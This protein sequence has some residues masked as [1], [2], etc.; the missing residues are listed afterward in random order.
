MA[1]LSEVMVKK[2]KQSMNIIKQSQT[3]LAQLNP[4]MI[5]LVT[6][7]SLLGTNIT[8]AQSANQSSESISK[9]TIL[10]D[11]AEVTRKQTVKCSGAK[12]GVTASFKAL[13]SQIQVK[14]LRASVKGP[15]KVIGVTHKAQSN[16]PTIKKQLSS[17]KEQSKSQ[18]EW[19]KK[20]KAILKKQQVLV[21]EKVRIKQSEGLV[22][23]EKERVKQAVAQGL[24]VGQLDFKSLQQ[25]L[26]RLH[27]QSSEMQKRLI[28]IDE[29]LHELRLE[30]YNLSQ[31]KP[32]A[33]QAVSQSTQAAV[34]VHGGDAIVSMNCSGT[35]ILTVELSYVTAGASWQ[36][37][38][39]V[40]I[41]SKSKNTA[42]VS[43][44]VNAIVRQSTGEDWQEAQ[45]YLS[46]AQPNLGDRSPLPRA[47]HIT[48]SEHS[49]Q[50]VLSQR[51]E[52]RQDLAGGQAQAPSE[53]SSVGIEDRGQS[54]GLKVPQKLTILSNGQAYWIPVSVNKT[55]KAKLALVSTP[56]LS[57]A[58]YKVVRFNNP[59]P[60]PMP[61]GSLALN[62]DGQYLGQ[63]TTK[64]YGQGEPVEF[65]LGAEESLRVQ[66][67]LKKEKDKKAGLLESDQTLLRHFEIKLSNSSKK[68]QKVEVV[69]N[70]PVS[71]IEDIKVTLNKNKARGAINLIQKQALFRG[72]SV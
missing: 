69:D 48:G 52:D 71:E 51:T 35:G 5:G 36:F 4:I 55:K 10:S 14:T 28:K 61:A 12:S 57:A 70:I 43:W 3:F 39:A 2:G 15:A 9:V 62:F 42:S 32:Q 30:L 31:S 24:H 1:S 46:T 59:A 33:S 6:L 45:V 20:V 13:P 23:Q 25:S 7:S 27:K 22:S 58:V 26:V 19:D 68:V 50:K 21:A 37:D 17:N 64:H 49:R 41:K 34:Q 67:V 53:P 65:T 29:S 66:R 60:H 18:L 56:K 44:S 8:Y 16:K 40:G 54:F 38:Y 11:R 72:K 47:L 63:I